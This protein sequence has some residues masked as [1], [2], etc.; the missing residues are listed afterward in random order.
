MSSVKGFLGKTIGGLSREYYWRHF[1][2][3]VV[4]FTLPFLVLSYVLQSEDLD[5]SLNPNVLIMAAMV[6]VLLCFI[7][8][9]SRFTYDRIMGFIMGD[10]LYL[11]NPI[12]LLIWR[13]FVFIICMQ[14]AFVLAP[15]G[16]IYLYFYHT[17]QER[18]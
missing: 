10:T 7:Y 17:K 8:P 11:I 14:F 6:A 3:A 16:L 2:F 9:Y 5:F 15:L 13:F 4:I 18:S 12:V 1:F